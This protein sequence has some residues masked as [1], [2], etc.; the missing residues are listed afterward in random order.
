MEKLVQVMN[1]YVADLSVLYRKLQNYHW[2]VQGKGFM[3]YHAKL[4]EYYNGINANIDMVAEQ[5]L[6]CKGQPLG[7]MKDYLAITKIEEAKNEKVSVEHVVTSVLKDFEYC[8]EKAFEVKELSEENNA[9]F[10]AAYMDEIITY[11]SKEIWILTQSQ[12]A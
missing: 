1:E 7:T 8:K 4:E 2:N 6:M 3:V 11:L 5:I 10:V 9:V 12:D